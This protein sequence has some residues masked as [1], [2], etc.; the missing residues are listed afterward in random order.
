MRIIRERQSVWLFVGPW[1]SR[2]I[3]GGGWFGWKDTDGPITR[4]VR[5]WWS[6][7]FR[8]QDEL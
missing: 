7:W 5:R 2:I 8:W 3:W 1:A 6:G 4:F